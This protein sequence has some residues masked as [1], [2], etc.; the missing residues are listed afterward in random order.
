MLL[1]DASVMCD[2][3]ASGEND[4]GI[5]RMRQ[6]IMSFLVISMSKAASFPAVAKNEVKCVFQS[7]PFLYIAAPRSFLRF[8]TS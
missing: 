7:A 6:E 4:A 5:D 2:T 1:K 3:V 8:S